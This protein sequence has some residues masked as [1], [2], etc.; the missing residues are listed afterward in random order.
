[1]SKRF[2]EYVGPYARSGVKFTKA[3]PCGGVKPDKEG[4]ISSWLLKQT[5]DEGFPSAK[6]EDGRVASG[7]GNAMSVTKSTPKPKRYDPL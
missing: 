3:D 5:G 7:G 4:S 1:M 6:R 2:N